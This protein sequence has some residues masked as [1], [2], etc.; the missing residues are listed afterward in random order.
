[1]KLPEKSLLRPCSFTSKLCRGQSRGR[2]E[3]MVGASVASSKKYIIAGE[4]KEAFQSHDLTSIRKQKFQSLSLSNVDAVVVAAAAAD[5]DAVVVADVHTVVVAT[6]EVDAVNVVVAD[7]DAVVVSNA[8]VDPVV[9]AF[10]DV[11]SVEF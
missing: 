3:K 5:S 11:D 9:V 6:A 4:G 1:M 10:T 2:D 7:M 8:D